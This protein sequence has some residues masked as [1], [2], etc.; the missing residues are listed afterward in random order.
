MIDMKLIPVAV[1]I[2]RG[3]LRANDLVSETKDHKVFGQHYF[4]YG[5]TVYGSTQLVHAQVPRHRAPPPTN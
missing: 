3:S 4:S 2:V 1:S 5:I